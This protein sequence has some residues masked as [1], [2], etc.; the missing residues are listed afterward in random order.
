MQVFDQWKQIWDHDKFMILPF[1]GSLLIWPS[2]FPPYSFH[3]WFSSS[4]HKI[5]MWNWMEEMNRNISFCSFFFSKYE[6][7]LFLLPNLQQPLIAAFTKQSPFIGFHFHVHAFRWSTVVSVYW[8][9]KFW[10][11]TLQTDQ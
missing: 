5:F 1:F 11:F 2:N 3:V 7:C 10:E 6:K 8:I 4:C 9:Y